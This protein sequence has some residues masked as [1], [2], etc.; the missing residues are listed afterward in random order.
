MHQG[1]N[2]CASVLR[3]TPGIVTAQVLAL[4]PV[5][6]LCLTHAHNHIHNLLWFIHHSKKSSYPRMKEPLP[7]LGSLQPL[8]MECGPHSPSSD[9]VVSLSVHHPTP[10]PRRSKLSSTGSI[11]V[12]ITMS[13][14]LP[15]L[16]LKVGLTVVG[17][18]ITW[19]I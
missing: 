6:S 19:P 16:I 10:H 13:Y 2:A 9:W 4:L 12:A 1:Q 14:L 5:E 7:S 3:A 18:S 15:F 17:N 11:G 8:P